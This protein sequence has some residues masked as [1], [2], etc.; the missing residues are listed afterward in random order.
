MGPVY[1]CRVGEIGNLPVTRLTC[2]TTEGLGE[3]RPIG[4]SLYP[5]RDSNCQ[6]Q[7]NKQTNLHLGS[8]LSL[9]HDVFM[10]FLCLYVIIDD[11]G[12]LSSHGQSARSTSVKVHIFPFQSVSM[13]GRSQ[14][15]IKVT[16]LGKGQVAIF[17][18]DLSGLFPRTFLLT[19]PTKNEKKGRKK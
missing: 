8:R 9:K 11:F 15:F 16:P 18:K 4:R 3:N 14:M 2:Q 19:V 12:V 6:K 17:A 5:E 7:T 10:M 1:K 13:F